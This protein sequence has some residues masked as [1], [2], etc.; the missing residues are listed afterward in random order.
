MYI[1]ESSFK[2]N[3]SPNYGYALSGKKFISHEKLR[4]PNITVVAAHDDNQIL[5]FMIFEGG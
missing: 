1:D 3:L 5:G 4:R 2:R